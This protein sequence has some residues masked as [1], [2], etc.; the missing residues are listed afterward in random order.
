MPPVLGCNWLNALIDGSRAFTKQLLMFPTILKAKERK[1]KAPN[2]HSC[3]Q[4]N[5][6]RSKRNSK[7][8]S[9]CHVDRL[10]GHVAGG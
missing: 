10:T 6:V 8:D 3:T 5:E 2:F 4:S 9:R 7:G 1:G